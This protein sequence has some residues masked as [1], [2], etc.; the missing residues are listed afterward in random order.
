MATSL[1]AT[2]L[3]DES[4]NMEIVIPGSEIPNSARFKIE[5]SF[6]SVRP[7][8]VQEIHKIS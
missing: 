5:S 3:G 7:C 1:D 6:N 8:N 2:N 4:G